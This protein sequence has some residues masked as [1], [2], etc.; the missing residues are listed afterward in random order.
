[1]KETAC[2]VE[3][4]LFAFVHLK[5]VLREARGE[6]VESLSACSGRRR[7]SVCQSD[8]YE[9]GE[10]GGVWPSEKS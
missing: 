10:G 3:E 9:A 5:R 2:V 6:P 1:M 4:R 8:A 7:E